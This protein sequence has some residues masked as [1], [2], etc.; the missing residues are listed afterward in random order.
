[1]GQSGL[2]ISAGIASVLTAGVLLALKLL[3]WWRSDAVSL[4][5]SAVDSAL[6]LLSSAVILTALV[7]ATRPADDNHRYGHGKAEALAGFLQGLLIGG[8]ALFVLGK[9]IIGHPTGAQLRELD[10][11]LV[12]MLISLALTALL[13]L[14][15]GFVSRRT[16]STAVRADRLHYVSDLLANTVIIAALLLERFYPNGWAD[17]M[18]AGITA[19]YVG[20][21]SVSILQE[22]LDVLMDRDIS[23]RYRADIVAFVQE[24][25]SVL[26]YHDLRSR[27]AGDHHFLEV[28]LEL[29]EQLSFYE[30]HQ[31][32][33]ELIAYL[34]KRHPKLEVTVHSDPAQL[35]PKGNTIVAGEATTGDFL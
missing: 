29:D 21:S 14:Y 15:Q 35:D 27:S 34:S 8:S 24:H 6:D 28:H 18:G 26:G 19:L 13:V 11:G 2:R 7:A 10:G 31:L 22:S 5:A 20:H 25:S 32:V 30:S 3:W 12:V 23:H 1:M 9:A 17:R 16:G 33:E 4:L